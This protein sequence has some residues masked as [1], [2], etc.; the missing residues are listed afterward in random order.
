MRF[1]NQI[2]TPKVSEFTI[3]FLFSLVVHPTEIVLKHAKLVPPLYAAAIK[4]LGGQQLCLAG[5][6]NSVKSEISNNNT[7][8]FLD[9]HA[10]SNSLW[11]TILD[12]TISGSASH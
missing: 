11:N 6:A 10:C 4:F 5:G 8:V 7:R 1:L 2:C 12:I 3:F 9:I